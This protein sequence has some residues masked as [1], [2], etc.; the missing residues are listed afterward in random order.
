MPVV[1]TDGRAVYGHL[2]TKFSWMGSLPDFLPMVLRGALGAQ[3]LRYEV[4]LYLVKVVPLFT[5]V[6]FFYWSETDADS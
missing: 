2:I 4:Y 6:T 5:G 1:R 3:E